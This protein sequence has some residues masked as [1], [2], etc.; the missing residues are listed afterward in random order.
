M[1]KM[2]DFKSRFIKEAI[3]CSALSFGEFTL[4]SGRVSPYFFNAG[5]FYHGGS[6]SAVGH[7]YA[8]AIVSSGLKFDMLFGPAYKGITLAA[9]TAIA[10]HDK[11]RIDAPYSYNRKEVKRHGEQ[12]GFVGSPLSGKV[13]I[14]DDVI[15]AGTAV[16]EAIQM[17]HLLGEAIVV[18]VVIGLDRRERTGDE[19][20]AARVIE[21]KHNI[22]VFSIINIDDIYDF[23]KSDSDMSKWAEPVRRYRKEFGVG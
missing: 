19:R 13:L 1:R 23:L 20:S 9:A 18:G 10:L 21:K 11:Y 4:K 2:K 14:V 12:G 6:L 3:D 22:P 17:I 15:T 5:R 7:C 8:E 16:N